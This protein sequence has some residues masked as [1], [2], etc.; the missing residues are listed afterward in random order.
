MA[1]AEVT[2]GQTAGT[3]MRF[4]HPLVCVRCGKLG[5]AAFFLC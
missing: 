3:V 2:D 5:K 4:G 1:G